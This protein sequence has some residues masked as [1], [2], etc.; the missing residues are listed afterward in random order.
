MSISISKKRNNVIYRVSSIESDAVVVKGVEEEM[1]LSFPQVASLLRLSFART[2][3]GCQGTEFEEELRLHDTS[4]RHFTMRH[5]FVGMSRCK[6]RRK[7]D[8]V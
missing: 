7:L 4:N 3:A 2:Y 8:I 6:D 5:L 1:K